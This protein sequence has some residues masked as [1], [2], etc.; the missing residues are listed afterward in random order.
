M[1]DDKAFTDTAAHARAFAL[2]VG[3]F[4]ALIG[5]CGVFVG[6]WAGVAR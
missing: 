6:V 2:V 5:A 1:N 4:F 3:L